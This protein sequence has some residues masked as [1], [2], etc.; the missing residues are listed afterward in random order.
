MSHGPQACAASVALRHAVD[1]QGFD[2]SKRRVTLHRMFKRSAVLLTGHAELVCWSVLVAAGVGL[3]IAP[4]LTSWGLAIAGLGFAAFAALHLA[5]TV[6]RQRMASR[7]ALG[8]SLGPWALMV[9]PD[10]DRFDAA[11]LA[12]GGAVATILACAV[13]PPAR[14]TSASQRSPA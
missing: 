13:S 5:G 1:R 7:V 11:Q 3:L 10:L 14:G 4:R 12:V 2:A 8:A 9:A 6:G